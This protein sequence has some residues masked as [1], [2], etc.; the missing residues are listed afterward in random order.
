MD[1]A[2]QAD[3]RKVAAC[4]LHAYGTKLNL[5]RQAIELDNLDWMT[6]TLA[7]RDI[8]P[9]TVRQD[10]MRQKSEFLACHTAS[11]SPNR[12]RFFKLELH[13]P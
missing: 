9:A 10:S 12:H 11:H 3:T 6:G 8:I 5:N 7:L 4:V 2:E 1:L 13:P